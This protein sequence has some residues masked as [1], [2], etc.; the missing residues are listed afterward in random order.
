MGVYTR[1]NPE[2][3]TR[4]GKSMKG[5]FSAFLALA[6]LTVAACLT[7]SGQQT[8]SGP[9]HGDTL[10]IAIG[11]DPDT[12]D[13]AALTTT[14]A[15]QIVDMMAEPLTRLD[16]N[17]KLKPWLATSWE[18]SADKL[19]WTFTLRQ[20]VK[21]QDGTPFNAQAVKFSLDR[22]NDPNTFK[23][24][25]GILGKKTGGIQQ[26]DAVDDSHVRITLGKPLAILD[27]V[28]G[29][30]DIISPASA[31]LAPNK[32]SVIAQPVGTGPYKF[33][34]RVAGDHISLTI[35]KDY[36]GT[37]PNYDTQILKVVPEAASRE[38]LVKSGGADV[39]Y[40][41]P[42]NDIPA[43]QA[44]SSLKVIFG[45]SDRTIQIIINNQDIN[46]PL[47]NKP[48]VR[49][50]LN[51]AVDKNAII[52]TVMFGAANTIDAPMS[53]LIF[54]Y[55]SV[56]TYNY[57]PA[58]AKQLLQSAGATGMSVKMVSPTGRYV[59]DFQVASAV[60]GYLRDV[61]IKVDGPSTTDWPTYVATYTLATPATQKA[62]L[63]LLGWAPQYMDAS[64]VFLQFYSTQIPP[65]GQESSF[66]KNPQ[67]DDLIAR[68]NTG[69]DPAQRQKDFCAAAKIVWND[70]PW[71]FLYNQ[72]FPFVTT[73]KVTGVYG[74]PTEKFV[75][76]WASP[77]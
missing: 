26:V 50:A 5:R 21:F 47:L 1:A 48:E 7:G 39:I 54:G 31:N 60:A 19:T 55:C 45:P 6:C 25:P 40:L 22:F 3:T 11:I 59:Q 17:G 66:Y 44:D 14:T 41:P 56:G 15:G 51:Y 35:N 13:P 52:K 68:A 30:F 76:T 38:A 46:Q 71:I 28:L 10:K 63:H 20:N 2:I 8:T 42:A 64:Q 69:T 62:D 67:V 58:K 57:D 73:S 74:L 37:R 70:A 75:T 4:E 77:S 49:Q 16:Q 27:Q 12:L 9:K 61:G 23:A 34:E 32:P 36:W 53:K 29:G 65:N 43:M 33:S 18:S 72:K 24:Q